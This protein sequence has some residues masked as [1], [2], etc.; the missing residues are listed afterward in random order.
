[1]GFNSLL[2]RTLL[3]PFKPVLREWLSKRALVLPSDTVDGI[4]KKLGKDPKNPS[5][6][7]ELEELNE[8]FKRF[9]LE[10]L[11]LWL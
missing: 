1:M 5:D 9:V 11:D 8:A 6:R 3:R 10:A 7:K 4:L 2:I